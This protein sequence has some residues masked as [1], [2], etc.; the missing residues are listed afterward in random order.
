MRSL[1]KRASVFL[2]AVAVVM[3]VAGPSSNSRTLEQA[4]PAASAAP[5]AEIGAPVSG[6]ADR[7]YI[8]N[9]GVGHAADAGQWTNSI[10][11]PNTPVDIAANSHLIKH[12]NTWMMFDTSTSD[13]TATLP[14][15]YGTGIHWVKTQAQ[16]LTP[17]LKAIGIT[18]DDITLIGLSHN[19]GDHSGNL[20][21][22]KKAEL[23]IQKR[24]YDLAFKTNP[25]IMGPPNVP[26]FTKDYPHKLLDGD[27]DVFGDGSVTLFFTGGH[28]L[29]HQVCLVRLRNTGYVLLSGDSVHLRSNLDTRRIPR[30]QG[31]NDENGW[32]WAVPAA[33]DRDAALMSYYHAQIWVHHDMDDYKG[34][35]FAPLYYE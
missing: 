22:F 16:T 31:A 9:G 10:L 19:H 29:G 11:P 27:Y 6:F 13:V 26:V 35:K 24:E 28:T 20:P 32:L 17:Q 33:F 34:R 25:V 15:G 14:D 18:P 12:G 5:K 21:L 3:L 1:M 23:L 30:V 8:L 4:K 2:A 7:L